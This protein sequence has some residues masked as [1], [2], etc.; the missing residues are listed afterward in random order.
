[1]LTGTGGVSAGTG[2]STQTHLLVDQ[3]NPRIQRNSFVGSP[4]SACTSGHGVVL[5]GSSS[6]F[7]NNA[8]IGPTCANNTSIGVEV[9]AQIRT[10]DLSVPSPTLHSNS[11][12]S[13]AWFGSAPA[14][15][16][17]QTGIRLS[18]APGMVVALGMHSG[19]FINNIIRAGPSGTRMFAFEETSAALDPSTLTDNDFY[20]TSPGLDGGPPLYLDEGLVTFTSPLAIDA[21]LGVTASGSVNLAPSFTSVQNSF[22]VISATSPV[23][24]LGPPASLTAPTDDLYGD[25]RPNPADAGMD[26]GAYEVP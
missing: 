6:Q 2:S 24:G 14:I 16:T 13:H 1:M 7:I 25:P 3:S 11:I 19:T 23:R 12:L 10:G 8:V 15:P 26:I 5:E 22:P 17:N 9:V 4:S 21:Q 18:I 20:I